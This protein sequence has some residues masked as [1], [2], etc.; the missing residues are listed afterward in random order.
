MSHSDRVRPFSGYLPAK[1]STHL[2][3]GSSGMYWNLDLM[4]SIVS[5]GLTSSVEG[6]EP[7]EE[8]PEYG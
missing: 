8:A 7:I 5:P 1:M 6:A 3:A 2:N 4:L